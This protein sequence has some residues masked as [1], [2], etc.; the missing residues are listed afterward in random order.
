MYPAETKHAF[1]SP[2]FFISH[3]PVAGE[4]SSTFADWSWPSL[5]GSCCFC[6]LRPCNPMTKQSTE[7]GDLLYSRKR[8]PKN[9]C[10]LA[11]REG[12]RTAR[13]LCPCRKRKSKRRRGSFP[14]RKKSEEGRGLKP[15]PL[16]LAN[17]RKGCGDR[18]LQ[19]KGPRTPARTLSNPVARS[20]MAQP[21]LQVPT[22]RV[23]EL[24]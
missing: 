14:R 6:L 12:G 8:H 21:A 10:A 2:P 15:L 7:G 4:R 1:P 20:R 19:R 18:P 22:S 9:G 5:L 13:V 3:P 24:S 17:E 16:A 23:D 11:R